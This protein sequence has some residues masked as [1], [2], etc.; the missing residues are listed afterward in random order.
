V[1]VY[2]RDV[3]SV[4]RGYKERTE[5]AR[6]RSTECVE[7]E[8]HK[9]GDANTV[10]VAR[11]VRDKMAELQSALPDGMN[12]TVLFDQSSFIKQS[13]DDVR[14][15]A[16]EGSVLAIAVLVFFLRDLRSA[17][18]IAISIPLSIIATFMFM[19]RMN[20][21][22]NIMSLGG[23]T[24]GV[25]MLVDNS[26]V[27]LEAIHRQRRRGLDLVRAAIQ[28]TTEVGPAV[29]ASSL[30]AVAV[31][32][33]ILFVEGVAGQLFKDQAL[34]VSISHTASLAVALTL[35]PMLSAIGR[36]KKAHVVARTD[37]GSEMT[38]GWFSRYYDRA[39]R[40]ALHRPWATVGW[41]TALFAGSMLLATR[42]QSELI[43]TLDQGQYFFEV[44]LPEGTS[45]AATDRIIKRMEAAAAAEPL[46]ESYDASVGSRQ[47]A[48]GMSVRTR[49]ENLGQLNVVYRK[50]STPEARRASLENLR[51][52]FDAIPDLDSK[53]S[54]PSYFTLK[55]P[56][57][58]DLYGE[59]L[60]PLREYS[61]RIASRLQNI[62]G[63]VD[64]RTSLEAG[65]PELQVI[66]DRSRLAALGL[67]MGQMSNSPARSRQGA[68][69]THY[70]EEDRQIDIRVRNREID[71]RTVED[72]RNL[73]ITER[74]G[75]P[76]R[77]ASVAS[78][79]LAA[80]RRKSTG[81]SSS[82][83]PS[84]PAACRAAASVARWRTSKS[85]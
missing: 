69:P 60:E 58:I 15:A 39:V 33:P 53:L 37:A 85:S 57:E 47:A 6:T 21:S 35:V 17:M 25:G 75:V 59:S 2:L 72:I 5:I 84:S 44:A 50:D 8:I 22:L 23:L 9:E 80:A 83:P 55:T 76:V 62:P 31:F 30:T 41:A 28:G 68:V 77:L 51:Q 74:N 63:L 32:L 4:H 14:R 65:N 26:I 49:D 81:S 54:T 13:I 48:G 20:V 12:L 82:A 40:R 71:R 29:I 19:Y 78:V 43:P 10:E 45:V 24:L 7:I 52:Q 3:A 16:V 18:I 64:L 73:V 79:E 36:R 42:L 46:I 66:F 34:T 56:I 38:L 27:V 67:D 1:P 61:A 11:A 70:K